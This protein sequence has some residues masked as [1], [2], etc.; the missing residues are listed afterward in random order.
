MPH[1]V[2]E[3]SSNVE[4]QFR[5]SNLLPKLH[6]AVEDSGL[7]DPQAIKARSLSYSDIVLPEGAQSFV[8]ITVSILSGRSIEQRQSLNDAVFAA[9][10]A[11]MPDV[12]KPSSDIREMTVET[13]R[14]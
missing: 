7:F 12:D 3:Y 4:A 2:V 6:K 14:K 11:A 13:Y 1:I 9:L 10:K 5:S 8:H